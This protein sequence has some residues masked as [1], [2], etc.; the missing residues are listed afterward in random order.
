MSPIST[1]EE[2]FSWPQPDFLSASSPQIANWWGNP[3]PNRERRIVEFKDKRWFVKYKENP[4]EQKRDYL[5][6]LLGRRWVN[7]CEVHSLDS[8]EFR[9]LRALGVV[10][11]QWAS[12]A[13]TFLVRL[14]QDY[15]V[16]E[17]SNTGLDSA[18]AT[19]LVFSLWIRRRDTHAANRR[20][21]ANVPI[22]FD[23]QTAF[24]GEPSLQDLGVFFDPN[25]PDAGYASRWRVKKVEPDRPVTTEEALRLGRKGDV[26]LHFIQDLDC[27]NKCIQDA[28]K[29]V[30]SQRSEEWYEQALEARFSQTLAQQITTF[31]D[32]A[33]AEL[34]VAIDRMREVIFQ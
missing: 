23:H 14:C 12:E 29:R 7:V 10:T 16:S 19:E 25:G 8:N 15:Q 1:N 18:V 2:P 11:P 30:Q 9:R 4:E 21:V 20:Y 3:E 5:A 17:L 32:N 34:D 13:N 27:F 26:A 31:L 6:Y 33:S 22:F 24:L 28:V